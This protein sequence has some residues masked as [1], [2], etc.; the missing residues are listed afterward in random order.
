MPEVNNFKRK[1]A[2]RCVVN[3]D[4]NCTPSDSESDEEEYE[5]MIQR[6]IFRRQSNSDENEP[7]DSIH[8]GESSDSLSSDENHANQGNNQLLYAAL[9]K[10]QELEKELAELDEAGYDS[11]HQDDDDDDDV[12]EG[13]GS[14]FERNDNNLHNHRD[15]I[16]NGEAEALGFAF[17]IKETFE[18]LAAQGITQDNPIFTTLRNRFLRQCSPN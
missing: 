11:G 18:Y 16:L 9:Q 6:K 7:T 4:G 13:N 17:C 3:V 8:E 15:E 14:D 1:R 10:I 5:R 2:N 12:D